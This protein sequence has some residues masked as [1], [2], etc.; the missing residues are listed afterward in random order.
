MYR[1]LGD[2]HGEARTG[3]WLG[4]L[5]LLFEELAGR[6]LSAERICEL[7]RASGPKWGYAKAVFRYAGF[8]IWTDRAHSFALAGEA[9]DG[10]L[11]LGDEA[12]WAQVV[13]WRNFMALMTDADVDF[14][15]DV[16]RALDTLDMRDDERWIRPD[17]LRAALARER[18]DWEAAE[19][20]GRRA[21]DLSRD[22]PDTSMGLT[23]GYLGWIKYDSGDPAGA[24]EYF[25]LAADCYRPHHNFHGQLHVV[26]ALMTVAAGS[27]RYELGARLHGAAR[28]FRTSLVEGPFR[29]TGY[30]MH[31]W[32]ARRYE[33]SLERIRT[34]LTAPEFEAAVAEGSGWSL[35]QAADVATTIMA[36][37]RIGH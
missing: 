19:R 25:R 11:E 18:S 9:A 24:A 8:L 29:E 1:R 37:A 32:D 3:L 4:R 16:A 22:T 31:E 15:D 6:G 27:G 5:D 23:A 34:N 21:L 17:L 14:D 12:S 30:D 26:E 35:D 7:Y 36:G 33:P 10:F 2:E 13:V 28:A 20:H